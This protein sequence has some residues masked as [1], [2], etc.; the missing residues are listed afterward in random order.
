MK[1]T[2]TA[3]SDK[4]EDFTLRDIFTRIRQLC[5]EI[6]K[7]IEQ[8]STPVD[9]NF[10]SCRVYHS[11]NQAIAT[12]AGGG[13]LNFD[14]ERWDTD[15]LH[16]K[17]TLNNTIFI[18]RTGKW[19]VGV[20][21]RYEFNA[22]GYRGV[23]LVKNGTIVIGSSIVQAAP[24]NPTDLGVHVIYEFIAGEYVSIFTSQNSG[25]NLNVVAAADQSPEFWVHRLS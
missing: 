25:G 15:G 3:L 22:A 20:G 2:W 16:D 12:G 4:L 1:T 23:Q 8:L 9:N 24:V 17:V 14:S 7:Q 6:I 21:I 5:D 13:T 18:N 11:A 19:A 10:A